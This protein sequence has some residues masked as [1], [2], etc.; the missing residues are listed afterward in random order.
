VSALEPGEL[1]TGGYTLVKAPSPDQRLIHVHPGA[2][3]LGSVYRADV[4][5]QA[6][7]AAFAERLA[8]I[9][10]PDRIAWKEHTRAARAEY[11]AFSQPRETPG[12]V[13]LEQVVTHISE[14]APEDAVITNGA[15]NYAGWVHR[16]FRYRGYR[17]QL[18][19]TAGSMGYGVPAA[20]AAKLAEPER[21]VISFNG[22]GCFLMNGQ[23]LATAMQYELP[24]V[25]IVVNNSMYGTIRM[26]QER[27]YPG[28]VS[29]TGLRNP[30]FAAYARSF[31]ANGETVERT[32]DFPAVFERA[33]TADAPSLI[34]LKVDPR[35]I[36][37][38]QT[39][40]EIR[41]GSP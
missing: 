3:E 26:H 31:G 24:V 35:A 12:A 20:V 30:D 9:A 18:A 38:A 21:A 39:L 7:L 32:E 33:L 29:G 14:S 5:V 28:R 40:E 41:K 15:G 34:E 8:D 23:E 37:P 4:P 6:G 22:D 1:T 36:T 13:K 10:A 27:D 17:S 2:E 25:F 19:T 16:Y 11:E